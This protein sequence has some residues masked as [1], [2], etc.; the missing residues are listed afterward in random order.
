VAFYRLYVDMMLC[1]VFS[2]SCLQK[3]RVRMLAAWYVNQVLVGHGASRIFGLPDS[4]LEAF[5]VSADHVERFA[6]RLGGQ[7]AT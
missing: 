3:H 2:V 6:L 1:T 5:Q 7:N 4:V